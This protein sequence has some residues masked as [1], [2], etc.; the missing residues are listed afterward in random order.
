MTTL[1]RFIP[2][3]FCDDLRITEQSGCPFLRTQSPTVC[4]LSL[5][6]VFYIKDVDIVIVFHL[7]P[8]SAE[9]TGAAAFI[10]LPV[11]L[12][13]WASP[14]FLCAELGASDC[15]RVPEAGRRKWELA[16]SSSVP[17]PR[18]GALEKI[19][20]E[21]E[22]RR[23]AEFPELQKQCWEVIEYTYI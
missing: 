6:L 12:Q 13:A 19:Q 8:S 14:F 7:T 17:L 1:P 20:A 11:S 2:H 15:T 3:R 10:N 9:Q 22:L 4:C 23:K 21:L 16:A 18:V 5:S